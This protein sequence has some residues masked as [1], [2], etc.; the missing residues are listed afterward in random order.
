MSW[1]YDDFTGTNG[2]NPDGSHWGITEPAS[3]TVDIQSN[4]LRMAVTGGA[5]NKTAVVSSAINLYGDPVDIQVDFSALALGAD[6]NVVDLVFLST[7][8]KYVR[9]DLVQLSGAQ[10][11][12]SGYNFGSGWTY[13]TTAARTN[14]NGKLRLKRI[15]TSVETWYQCGFAVKFRIS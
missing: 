7:T 5:T 2:D 3:T 12:R 8:G 1:T 4:A 13:P 9:I 15:G 6:N 10:K 11:F 14:N